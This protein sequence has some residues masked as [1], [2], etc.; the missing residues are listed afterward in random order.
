VVY[1]PAARVLHRV[2]SSHARQDSRLVR[3]QSRNEERVFWRNLPGGALRRA[4]PSH[5][6][7]LLAKA[8]R[9]TCE[10][11]LLP[12]LHGRRDAIGELP[13]LLRHRR[14]LRARSPQAG[15]GGWCVE[16]SWKCPAV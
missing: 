10:G 7:V 8:W 14:R 2:G 3:Q 13:A 5:V 12:F 9:R 15:L 1:E 16:T 4:L 11:N 6:L